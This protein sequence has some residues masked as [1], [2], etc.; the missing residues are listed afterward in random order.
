[1]DRE[2]LRDILVKEGIRADAYS[3]EGGLREDRLTID[4]VGH[5][6]VVYYVERGRRW[7]ERYFSDQ[8][9]A[10]RHLLEL[11]RTDRSAR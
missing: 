7:N 3:L 9:T 10:C 11:L 8:D 5:R 2:E 1:M 6:W 4:S